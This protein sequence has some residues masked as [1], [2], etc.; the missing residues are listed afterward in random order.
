MEFRREQQ[1]IAATDVLQA[2]ADGQD[3]SLIGCTISGDVEV[4]RF[5]DKEEKFNIENLNISIVDQQRVVT[6][7]QKIMINQ[8]VFEDKVFFSPK[9]DEEQLL[10]VVFKQDAIFNLSVFNNQTRFAG[11]T[12]KGRAGFDGC[13]FL[14]VAAFTDCIFK[15]QGM[16]RTCEFRGYAL[17]N[18]AFFNM[19]ARFINTLLSKG[20]NFKDTVFNS[21]LDFSGVYST[22]KSIP[23]YYGIKFTQKHSGNGE[24]FWRY[25]KQAS[26][27]AGYYILAGDCF[28]NER[29]SNIKGRLYGENYCD[30][31]PKDKLMRW[32]KGV[33]LL[34]EYIFGDMLFGYGEK[35]L[36][37]ISV[38]GAIITICGLLYFFFG[39]LSCSYPPDT[40]DSFFES[41][42][43]SIITFTTLG[44]GDIY[45]T[46]TDTFTRVVAMI[47]ALCG[48][49]L[50][51]LF[52]VCLSKRFSRG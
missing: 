35:P 14:S 13:K 43:F 31:S 6:F 21:V 23:T 12:F 3:I 9:W 2:L 34:P 52:V 47:E 20:G 36:R 11:C 15:A 39:S 27:E 29:K 45:P 10:R 33:R 48:M 50:I 22:G 4:Q 41:F 18:R 49:S 19:D 37:V 32:L 26:N 44:F 51:S 38:A 28:Y 25:V 16:F 8:C 24:T 17:F 30:L 5:F 42:Y 40:A 1:R 46:P 7:P